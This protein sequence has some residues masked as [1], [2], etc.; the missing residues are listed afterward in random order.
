M[1]KSKEKRFRPLCFS[2]RS[3]FVL[4]TLAALLMAYY[5][6]RCRVVKRIDQLIADG[7]NVTYH[8]EIIPGLDRMT[9]RAFRYV[10]SVDWKRKPI[11]NDDLRVLR[12]L[13]R[14]RALYLTGTT[15]DAEGLKHLKR[16]PQLRRL[17]LWGCPNPVSYTHLTLPTKA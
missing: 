5:Q 13:P 12:R 2:L 8:P 17:A 15:I 10:Y 3:A 14:L 16:C 4:V 6:H 11:E 9:G 7:A 1:D